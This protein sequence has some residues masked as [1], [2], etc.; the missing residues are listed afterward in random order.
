MREEDFDKGNADLVE[1]GDKLQ[2]SSTDPH[3]FYS[4][5]GA[6]PIWT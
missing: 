2:G 5:N 4:P 3:D 1:N 6:P